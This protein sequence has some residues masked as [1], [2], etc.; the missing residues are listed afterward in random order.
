MVG[1]VDRM[2]KEA[3]DT[4]PND[5]GLHLIYGLARETAAFSI[6]HIA[7]GDVARFGPNLSPSYRRTGALTEARG[8]FE[9]AVALNPASGEAR[10]RLGRIYI[11]LKD[12]E[13]AVPHLEQ[14]PD[15]RVPSRLPVPRVADAR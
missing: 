7:D 4:F 10:L 14:A 8:A 9:R 2:L 3:C 5:A 13:R 6:D 1:L 15:G 11:L 12:E